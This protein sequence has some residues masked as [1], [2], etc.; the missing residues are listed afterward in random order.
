MPRAIISTFRQ[1]RL[2]LSQKRETHLTSFKTQNKDLALLGVMI[3]AGIIFFTAA[4]M[5]LCFGLVTKTMLI[6]HQ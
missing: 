2:N 5:V 6:T 1:R 3:L 4:C